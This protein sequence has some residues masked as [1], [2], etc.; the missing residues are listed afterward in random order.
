MRPSSVPGSLPFAVAALALAAVATVA[1]AAP[2]FLP[3]ALRAVL[4]PPS[5]SSRPVWR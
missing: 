4:A 5:S 3:D 2:G 1:L